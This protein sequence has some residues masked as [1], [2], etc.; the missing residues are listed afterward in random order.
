MLAPLKY[1]SRV[2]RNASSQA[3]DHLHVAVVEEYPPGY[4]EGRV[5][6]VNSVTLYAGALAGFG[7]TYT[8][9]DTLSGL[10]QFGD[11]RALMDA[12]VTRGMHAPDHR[13]AQVMK[14]SLHC[15]SLTSL[16]S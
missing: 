8:A 14:L 7:S 4:L 6:N 10:E 3:S 13:A 2:Y 11:L 12:D 5:N 15:C 1:Y 16:S 9:G